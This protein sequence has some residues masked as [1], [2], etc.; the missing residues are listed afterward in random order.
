MRRFYMKFCRI[1]FFMLVIF[2]AVFSSACTTTETVVKR[3][4]SDV[5]KDLDG[6]WND[7]DV[8]IVC[9]NLISE[10]NKSVFASEYRLTHGR[11]P[12]VIIGQIKNASD[13]HID[14]TIVANYLRNALIN[15]G[16]TNFVS[17]STERSFLREERIDQADNASEETAKAIG[18]ETGADAMMLG[19]VR[20]IVQT[21]NNQSVRSYFVNVELHDLES[22]M[23]LWSGE[24]DSVKKVITRPKVKF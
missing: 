2:F 5:V 3:V 23:I 7:S 1:L 9:N 18:N 13:E 6:Y 11:K 20:T 14:T 4:G 12:V 8:R 22:N 17:S 19:S 24:D 21:L 16:A 15:S 10:F